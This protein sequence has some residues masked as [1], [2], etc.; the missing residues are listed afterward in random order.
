MHLYELT[1]E[2]RNLELTLLESDDQN[3]EALKA[4]FELISEQLNVKAESIAK[5][6]LNYDG[7]LEATAKELTRLD[8]RK[9]I[10]ENRIKY[11]KE[12][13]QEQMQN[14]HLEKIS[15]EILTITLAKNPMSI[16]VLDQTLVPKE[17]QKCIPEQW[18]VDKKSIADHIKLSGEIPPGIE[19]ITD[20]KS[21]RIR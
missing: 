13:L 5:I 8:A 20:K 17:Y 19:A 9:K 7:K 14:A 3:N 10:L 6:I 16:N 12:Y 2:Y 4:Q 1:E 18:V 15:G 11:L 21:V